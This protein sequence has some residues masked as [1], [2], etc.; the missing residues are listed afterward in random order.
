MK[1][2]KFLYEVP[3]GVDRY[4]LR[5]AA[6]ALEVEAALYRQGGQREAAVALRNSAKVLR[7]IASAEV[8][9]SFAEAFDFPQQHGEKP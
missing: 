3:S 7:R 6:A 5:K 2:P 8:S 1:I 4:G 9:H